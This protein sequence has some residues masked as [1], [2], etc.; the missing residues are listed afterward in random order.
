MAMKKA[1]GTT[2]QQFRA[3]MKEH[4][5]LGTRR[6]RIETQARGVWEKYIKQITPAV[7]KELRSLEW[8]TFT[9]RDS[10][11]MR[12]AKP[13]AKSVC[14]QVKDLASTGSSVVRCYSGIYFGTFTLRF[15]RVNSLHRKVN[16]VVS[17]EDLT[18]LGIELKK[19]RLKQKTVKQLKESGLS[20]DEI[21]E[22]VRRFKLTKGKK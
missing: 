20:D 6:F 18:R 8:E 17:A 4:S 16:I 3:L 12:R 13:P 19:R 11:G 22:A 2:V 14:L 9:G 5:D 1:K 7:I 10:K 21:Q 15:T